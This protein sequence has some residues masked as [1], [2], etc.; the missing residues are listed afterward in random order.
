MKHILVILAFSATLVLCF[1]QHRTIQSLVM[2]TGTDDDGCRAVLFTDSK[3]RPIALYADK[4]LTVPIA[5]PV[6][7]DSLG[8]VSVWV[9]KYD[10][11]YKFIPTC[12]IHN[13]AP[14]NK[15]EPEEPIDVPAVAGDWVDKG[16][17]NG[18]CFAVYQ[19]IESKVEKGRCFKRA[20]TCRNPKRILQHDE[21]GPPKYWC[22][23]VQPEPKP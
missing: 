16:N 4:H 5:N 8:N 7:A 22:H 21:Q 2:T 15:I 13:N 1:T 9:Q 19:Q 18:W 23:K 14:T 11:D 6:I 17:D 3:N 10:K 20:W 12:S